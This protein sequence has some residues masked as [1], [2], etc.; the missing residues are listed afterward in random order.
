MIVSGWLPSPDLGYRD[1]DDFLY[2]LN[3]R[4]NITIGGGVNIYPQDIEEVVVTHPALAKV[5][6]FGVP[7][8]KWGEV[9]AAAVVLPDGQDPAF[10]GLTE[11]INSRVTATFQRL[12]AC[13]ISPPFPRN[14]AGKTLER[15]IRTPGLI[16]FP[17]SITQSAATQR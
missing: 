6:V 17:L 3:H 15:E 10:P 1:E 13:F 11:W 12:V 14:V 2:V 5:A 7:D 8:E 16:L 9:P 4:K